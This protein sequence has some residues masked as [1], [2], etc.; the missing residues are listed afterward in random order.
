MAMSRT[1]ASTPPVPP[2]PPVDPPEA[3]CEAALSAW[4]PADE[5]SDAQA[6]A[7][8]AMDAQERTTYND[9]GRICYYLHV[10]HMPCFH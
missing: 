7:S 4:L 9:D 6:A 2:L 10:K 1:L 5:I 8:V 3:S